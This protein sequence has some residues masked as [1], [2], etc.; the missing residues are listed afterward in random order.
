VITE[1]RGIRT[2]DLPHL[3]SELHAHD[4]MAAEASASPGR[5]FLGGWNGHHPFVSEFV[6]DVPRRL[7]EM[8]DRYTE[9][10]HLDEDI[11]LQTRLSNLHA[12]V[13]GE[14][15]RAADSY[16]PGGGSSAFL[17]TLLQFGRRLG[18]DELCYL[19][20]V[21]YNAI[22]WVRELGFRVTRVAP[23]AALGCAG[24]V[25]ELPPGRTLLWLTD[26]V[27]FAGVG[28][29]P[30]LTEEVA[31]WQRATG[32]DIIVDGTFQYMRWDR[33]QSPE[34][35]SALDP[36]RTFRLVCPTKNLALHGFRFAYAIVPAQ[37]SEDFRD[38]NGRLH[39]AASLADRLFAHQAVTVLASA[40]G[41]APLWTYARSRLSQLVDAGALAE[42][43]PPST[44]YFVFG[45]PDRNPGDYIGLSPACFEVSGHADYTR[46]NLLDDDD[47][48]F[49]LDRA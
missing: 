1:R 44:G 6:G 20:P 35:T 34:L 18:H 43:V 14:P 17:A 48:S 30:G 3:L 16:I 33:P 10:S 23:H 7:T 4:D 8:R 2:D 42:L 37:H 49:L 41:A 12:D 39:G 9:Y 26:P 11:E 5:R 29:S 46:I 25:L 19:P 45:R 32:S 28:L 27:W 15:R 22:Y 47:F 38:F 40:E 24:A 21:Y 31:S 36:E 13:Y